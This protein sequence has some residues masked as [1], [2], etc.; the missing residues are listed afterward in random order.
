MYDWNTDSNSQPFIKD[1]K[2]VFANFAYSQ[3][4]F[5]YLSKAFCFQNKTP[6]RDKWIKKRDL[7]HDICQRSLLR[8]E[9]RFGSNCKVKSVS[10]LLHGKAFVQKKGEGKLKFAL[11]RF[12]GGDR[13]RTGVQT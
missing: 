5:Y 3:I 8:G 12:G 13:N 6:M 7:L 10:T 1:K 9:K 2:A 11:P 4:F